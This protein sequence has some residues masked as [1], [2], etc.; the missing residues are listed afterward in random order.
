MEKQII[1]TVC[2]Q[3]CRITVAGEGENITSVTGFTCPRGEAYARQEFVCPVRILTGSVRTRN[4]SEVLLPVR[5]ADRIPRDLIPECMKLLRGVEVTPPV[6]V[7]DVI[8][9][10]ILN[11]GVDIV[12]S[13]ELDAAR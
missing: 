10:N 3:G 12:A 1:C 6:R 9:K 4:A 8:V 2:P 5:S 13:G 11:T 7:R